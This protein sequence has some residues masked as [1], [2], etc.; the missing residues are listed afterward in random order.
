MFD[1]AAW[2]N[3]PILPGVSV[4]DAGKVIAVDANGE[5]VAE[6]ITIPESKKYYE[7]NIRIVE[8]NHN[9]KI[10]I[11]LITDTETAFTRTTLASWFVANNYIKTA[12]YRV[13]RFSEIVASNGQL[14]CVEDIYGT[15]S[16]VGYHYYV[17]T[18]T[19][20]DG[21]L[22]YS[23]TGPTDIAITNISINDIVR[24]L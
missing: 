15:P 1:V 16:T 8:D 14:F 4:A 3:E 9:I 5:L 12:P 6:T 19:I 7:H 18:P 20:T 2:S 21:V 11:V 24:E 22:S 17:Y 13:M 23:T 10:S